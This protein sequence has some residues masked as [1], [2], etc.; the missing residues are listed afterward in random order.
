MI[1]M[2]RKVKTS[3]LR[4]SLVQKI[5]L[6]SI[7]IAWV[8]VCN[9]YKQVRPFMACAGLSNSCVVLV[10]I[11]SGKIITESLYMLEIVALKVNYN[12]MNKMFRLF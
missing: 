6:V 11:S 5:S 4:E 3:F 7:K 12:D 1:H 10:C 9:N 2:L 8:K